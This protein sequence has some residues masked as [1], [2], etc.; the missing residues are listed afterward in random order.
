MHESAGENV[1]QIEDGID[2]L[3]VMYGQLGESH[4]D[5]MDITLSEIMHRNLDLLSDSDDAE[6]SQCLEDQEQGLID[7]EIKSESDDESCQADTSFADRTRHFMSKLEL[8]FDRATEGTMGQ[9]NFSLLAETIPDHNFGDMSFITFAGQEPYE[10]SRSRVPNM[11][12]DI[13]GHCKYPIQLPPIALQKES[14][15][16]EFLESLSPPSQLPESKRPTAGRCSPGSTP[17]IPATLRISTT[18]SRPLPLPTPIITSRERYQQSKPIQY[19]TLQLPQRD[20]TRSSR[21]SSV[22]L[23]TSSFS[24]ASAATPDSAPWS[25]VSTSLPSASTPVS[26]YN[27]AREEF[28]PDS[29]RA[30]DLP[31]LDNGASGVPASVDSSLRLMNRFVDSGAVSLTSKAKPT[32]RHQPLDMIIVRPAC[33]TTTTM[34]SGETSPWSPLSSMSSAVSSH[35]SSSSWSWY[36]P[37]SARLSKDSSPLPSQSSLCDEAL[38]SHT[39][40]WQVSKTTVRPRLPSTFSVPSQSSSGSVNIK[41]RSMS[42]LIKHQNGWLGFQVLDVRMIAS[43]RCH[44]VVITRSNQV[45]SCWEPNMD[46]YNKNCVIGSI[47]KEPNEQEIEEALGRRTKT[48]V[49]SEFEQDTTFQPGLV[50]FKDAVDTLTSKIMKIVCCDT[51]TFLLTENGDLWAWGFFEDTSGERIGLLNQASAARP[52]QICAQRIKDVV[53]GRNHVLILNTSGDVI[54]WGA[55]EHGQL[56]RPASS[57]PATLS[58]PMPQGAANYDLSPYFIENLPPGI[59]GIGAGKLSSFAWDE[60]RLYGWGD[61]TFGQLGRTSALN[62]SSR[63]QQQHRQQQQQ[64]ENTVRL[65]KEISL[66]WK[67]KSIKQVQGGERHTV[68]LTRSGLVVTM[69]NDDFGQL[70]VISSS[71]SSAS[72]ASN[73]LNSTSP[74]SV[75]SSNNG[76][77]WSKAES[78]TPAYVPTKTKTRLFPA[79][80]R[81]DAGVKEIQC[82][83]FHTVTCS[84]SGQMFTW[85]QG[86]DGIVAIHN[87]D[88]SLGET[89]RGS[90]NRSLAVDRAR[91]VVAVSTMRAGV[92]IALVSNDG[93]S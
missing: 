39:R 84:D 52:I 37:R 33:V 7:G 14:I 90:I 80:V 28:A 16:G 57:A 15:L 92:S 36:C 72:S 75:L 66:H 4:E 21:S 87:V 55:N 2:G 17:V 22:I 58:P 11:R 82:G 81:I 42:S 64:K 43:G 74:D 41:S 59:V 26:E 13:A 56:G 73:S 67:G 76:S 49:D 89:D 35:S 85:G 32:S 50:L 30:E 45:F 40:E 25:N 53:C 77:A 24:I 8:D 68:V 79:L 5:L 1:D 44:I 78:S 9:G 3:S 18:V 62:A 88:R 70:G 71:P 65:P 86:F 19:S 54:S 38:T 46:N 34:A 47:S 93:F 27:S 83:D 48:I 10:I 69:G 20:Q 29:F 61:N 6:S 63:I 51:A 60:E 23:E 31:A 91:R 12:Q